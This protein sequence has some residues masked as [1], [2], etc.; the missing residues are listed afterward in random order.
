MVFSV[1][2]GAR[3]FFCEITRSLIFVRLVFDRGGGQL[4]QM[5]EQSTVRYVL[6]ISVLVGRTTVVSAV[7]VGAKSS[8]GS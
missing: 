4:W 2:Y 1:R 6:G 8:V 7:V 5:S 3:P